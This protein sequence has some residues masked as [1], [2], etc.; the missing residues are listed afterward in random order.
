MRRT[1]N[2]NVSP[3]QQYN[4]ARLN[5]LLM[6]VFTLLN[7]VML[8]A[9]ANYMLLF[10][11][12]VPYSAVVMGVADGTGMLLVPCILVA[13]IALILYFLCWLLSKRSYSWMIVA[14]ALF[15]LDCV[16]L[17]GLYVWTGDFS[18]ILDLLIHIWV[19]YYL[20][21]GVRS[22]KQLKNAQEEE[23]P[24]QPQTPVGPEF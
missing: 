12:T 1:G 18:G 10:S 17:V 9:E 14:L 23:L 13:A 4:T 3:K 22:G 2:V 16:A 11:A 6:I 19:L 24:E 7:I 15:V 21:M 20:I 5:L 8:F